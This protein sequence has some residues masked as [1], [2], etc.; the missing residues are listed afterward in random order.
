MLFQQLQ[1]LL[2]DRAKHTW[3]SLGC[4]PAVSTATETAARQGKAHMGVSGVLPCCLN[5]Y[6]EI[7]AIQDKVHMGVSGVLLC[8]FNSYRDCC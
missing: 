2:L 7:A 1:R 3:V 5:S 6:R 8:C 4:Y